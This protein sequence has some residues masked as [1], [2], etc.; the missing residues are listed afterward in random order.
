MHGTFGCCNA[1]IQN[2]EATQIICGLEDGNT[3]FDQK[4]WACINNYY[5][6]SG[7]EKSW[8]AYPNYCIVLSPVI[9]SF[10]LHLFFVSAF[11]AARTTVVVRLKLIVA[12]GSAPGN[13][14]PSHY[15]QTNFIFRR[16]TKGPYPEHFPCLHPE[17]K[18]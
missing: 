12:A 6:S 1:L 14:Y 17:L 5:V 9:I 13:G 10:N 2:Y 16:L 4:T 7:G 3:K 11:K 18:R 15:N 8:H